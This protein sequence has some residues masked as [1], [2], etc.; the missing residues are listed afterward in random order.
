MGICASTEARVQLAVY[1]AYCRF[2]SLPE[3]KPRIQHAIVRAAECLSQAIEQ[4]PRPVYHYNLGLVL[5]MLDRKAEA[6]RMFQLAADSDDT[7]I[8]IKARKELGR[9]GPIR[10]QAMAQA[11][12]AAPGGPAFVPRK[13]TNWP[14]ATKGIVAV[15]I[16]IPLL[17]V[18]VIG[19]VVL[20]LGAFWLHKGFVVGLET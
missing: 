8:A 15:A 11:P 7:D 10:E 6:A 14:V 4:D 20:G 3:Y 5:T 17:A 19:L 13:K 9:L 2:A 1:D 16:G 12:Q 18:P